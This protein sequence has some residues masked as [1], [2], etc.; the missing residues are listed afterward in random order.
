MLHV[1]HFNVISEKS[2]RKYSGFAGSALLTFLLCLT[3]A[4]PAFG[5]AHIPDNAVKQ[6]QNRQPQKLMIV[7]EDSLIQQ[8]AKTRR[9]QAHLPFDDAAILDW[10]AKRFYRLKQQVLSSVGQ[11]Q[12]W[13]VRDYSHLPMNVLR[14]EDSNALTTF[15]QLPGVK[16]IYEIKTYFPALS[17]SLPLISQVQSVSHGKTGAGTTVVILDSGVDYTNAA[18]NS[19]TSPG[20]P[21]SCKVVE[22]FD[23]A[24]DDS[25]LDSIGHGTNVSGIVVGVAPDAKLAV[26]DI[27]DGSTTTS[28][29]LTGGINWAIA[30]QA[31][32]N[33]VALNMSLSDGGHYTSPCSTA[34][35][36]LVALNNAR[37]AGIIPVAASGN[38]GY[39]DAISNPA[40][41]P[42]T[43]SVG[44]VYDS[45]VGTVGFSSCTDDTTSADQPLCVSNS[46]DYL[47]LLA[48]GALI[49]AA[50]RTSGGTSQAAPHV[51]G[52]LAVLRSAFPLESLD[53]TL[54]RLTSNGDNIFD[55]RN[56]I[57]TSRVNLWAALGYAE[58]YVD[59]EIP[60]LPPWALA[61][62]AS[63]LITVANRKLKRY[64]SNR[65]TRN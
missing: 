47:D 46:A 12:V 36:L 32:Y 6:L 16:A 61:I 13:V 38:N 15:S 19:C 21:S 22:S 1:S 62:T 39:T 51:A 3:V 18:F 59:E 60:F 11:L 27:F 28:V 14:F 9:Q 8:E 50:G 17:E 31:A 34:N 35:P 4:V 44:G 33:I 48:P 64:K 65:Y 29:L 24:P 26:V 49:T 43:V 55:P 57:V 25:A 30:N 20:V 58:N 56:G 40:C 37:S 10:K 23:E 63:G 52:A 42:G 5:A 53:T 45:D 54:S 41:T 2:H 7:Y